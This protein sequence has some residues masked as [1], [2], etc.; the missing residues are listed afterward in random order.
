[1]YEC[2]TDKLREYVMYTQQNKWTG[3]KKP[4]ISKNLN[5]VLLLP[6]EDLTLKHIEGTIK[7]LPH[8]ELG[9]GVREIKEG[10]KDIKDLPVQIE[11]VIKDQ[12]EKVIKELPTFKQIENDI[13]DLKD[14]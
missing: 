11:K 7:G 1:F 13:K 4:Y 6:E 2:H 14:L 10:I 5:E 12:I 8:K 9:K 3:Y